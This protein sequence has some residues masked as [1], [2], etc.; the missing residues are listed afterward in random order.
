[1][2]ILND[3]VKSLTPFLSSP[4]LLPG[5]SESEFQARKLNQCGIKTHRGCEWFNTSVSSVLK[6]KNARDNLLNNIRNKHYSLKISKMIL[7]ILSLRL[8]SVKLNHNS[9]MTLV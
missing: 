3:L 8:I 1:M 4:K 2:F 5:E 7:K 6:R 9:V